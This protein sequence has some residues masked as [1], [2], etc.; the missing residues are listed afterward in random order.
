MRSHLCLE[1]VVQLESVAMYKY[2]VKQQ[3]AIEVVMNKFSL[4]LSLSLSS[5]PREMVVVVVVIVALQHP[6]HP[7]MPASTHK[8]AAV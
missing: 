5:L 4:S 6:V 1:I 3:I 8:M 7:V 2:L